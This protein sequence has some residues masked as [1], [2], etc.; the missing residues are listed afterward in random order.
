MEDSN[1][2]IALHW[3]MKFGFFLRGSISFDR[4]I[5]M[6]FSF[7]SWTGE[8]FLY[9]WL[10]ERIFFIV[11]DAF[12]YI[13]VWIKNNIP[14]FAIQVTTSGLSDRRLILESRIKELG[15]R[16]GQRYLK[17]FQRVK[18]EAAWWPGWAWLS[19]WRSYDINW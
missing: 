8:Y 19:E 11:L 12:L 5:K 9:T 10:Y 16:S 2:L 13:S 17:C 1:S 4:E 15:C 6:F 18:I 7:S 14:V 3:S